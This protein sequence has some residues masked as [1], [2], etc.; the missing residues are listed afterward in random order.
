[1][2]IIGGQLQSLALWQT[3]ARVESRFP[4][5]ERMSK[6]CPRARR[7]LAMHLAGLT[8]FSPIWG[9]R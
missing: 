2:I 8:G 5:A 9:G 4:R 7:G 1:M 6:W 3:G